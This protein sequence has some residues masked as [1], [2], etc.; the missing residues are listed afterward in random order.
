MNMITPAQL[1]AINA[2]LA[3]T[4][5][6]ENKAAIISN[7]TNGRT[8][9]T[10]ELLYEEAKQILQG[11]ARIKKQVETPKPTQKM[12]NKLFAIAHEMGWVKNVT[13]VG[14]NGLEVKKD[15]TILHN[16]INKYGYLRKPLNQYSYSE[17]PK[18]LYQFE[19]GVYKEY[20][21]KL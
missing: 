9:H 7:A 19:H 3:K 6:M 5:Q 21:S 4:G 2:I 20:L 10:S 16:W 18:L 8:T 13:S 14:K 12:I 15:Y 11:F 1:R 17:L